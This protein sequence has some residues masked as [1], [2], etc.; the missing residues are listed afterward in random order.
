MKNKKINFR[1]SKKTQSKMLTLALVLFAF[2]PIFAAAGGG[3]IGTAAESIKRYVSGIKNL[4]YA[5][6]IVVSFIGAIRIYNKWQNGD[7]DV[8]KEIM[9]WVG[10][11][12][13]IVLVPTFVEA[14]FP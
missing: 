6:A 5:I 1:M 10:A 8:N 14:I 7:Q 3:A 12:I 2:S 13:F 4:I 11:C 9:G